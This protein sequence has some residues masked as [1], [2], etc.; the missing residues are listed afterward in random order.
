[1]NWDKIK[2]KCPK[3]FDKWIKQS[4]FILLKSLKDIEDAYDDRQLYDFFDEQGIYIT[5]SISGGCSK[6]RVEGEHLEQEDI[7]QTSWVTKPRTEAEE[8]AF[9]KAFEILER[10]LIC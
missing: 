7:I 10:R 1:M 4:G 8:K 2:E 6:H 9:I 3:A 5:V